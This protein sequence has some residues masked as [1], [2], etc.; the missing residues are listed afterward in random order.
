LKSGLPLAQETVDLVMVG[1]VTVGHA[2][3]A[4]VIV[5]LMAMALEMAGRKGMAPVIAVLKD[6]DRVR[7]G[8]K[9]EGRVMV[10]SVLPADHVKVAQKVAVRKAGPKVALRDVQKVAG[11]V[12][13]TL[14][15]PVVPVK[16]A[17]KEDL[18]DVGLAKEA[19]KRVVLKV[20]RND[21]VLRTWNSWSR[22]NS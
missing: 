12:T 15:L 16:A 20:V 17:R 18:K 22:S 21:P 14:V 2:V 6:A 4:P 13:A 10:I 1:R 11:R 5:D 3:T 8:L 7:V 9:A 19:R